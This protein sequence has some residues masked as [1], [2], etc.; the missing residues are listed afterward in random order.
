MKKPLPLIVFFI[1]LALAFF[2]TRFAEETEAAAPKVS[3]RPITYRQWPNSLLMSNGQIEVVIVP[4]IGRVMQM[5]FVG[6]Q[7]GPFWEN[8]EWFG[9]S[10]DSASST[11][12]NFGGDKTWPA[13]QSEW[14]KITP[15]AWPP[16]VAFDSMPVKAEV[17]GE[18]VELVSPVDP[19]FG[20]RTRRT[21][22]LDARR[23]MV[24]IKTE[25]EKVEGA[26]RSVAIWIITQ[27][28]EAAAIFVPLPDQTINADGY[29]KHSKEL[30]ATLK[31]MGN[32]LF[33]TR[34]PKISTKIGTDAG[35]L[36]WMDAKHIVQIDSPRVAG[37]TYTH[38][39]SSAEVYTN[40]DPLPYVELEM[41]GPLHELKVG[42][43]IERT[44]TYTL[45]RRSAKTVD[46]EVNKALKLK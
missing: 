41:L 14:P 34:D 16:P 19:H 13:P 24:V 33:L 39:N 28:K 26:P 37:A 27:L 11:W 1:F 25:Y 46:E 2:V 15:R 43:R 5:R 35:T 6:E 20:I 17:K 29:V 7:D 38:K 32:L 9:K 18:N 31:R 4:A 23:P 10:P 44:N 8:A 30:P 42:D 40:A 12:G 21:V 22:S 3:I 45:A 36:V